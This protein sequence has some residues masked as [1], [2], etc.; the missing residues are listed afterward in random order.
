M[1]Y[2]CC[3]ALIAVIFTAS[4]QAGGLIDK[5]DRFTGNRNVRWNSVPFKPE[6]FG[7]SSYAFYLKDTA[8][9]AAYGLSLLTW[10]DQW[11]FLDCHRINWLV[12]GAPAPELKSKYIHE[13]AGSA[14]SERFE[15]RVDRDALK[16]MASA[17]LVEFSIC[18]QE[19]KVSNEDLGGIR[20]V[21][22]VAK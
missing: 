5:T 18:G 17:K 10:A 22:E 19:Y 20:Q 2:R 1:N 16:K 12:D 8:E 7:V 11:Q 21:L 15:F 9:P 6:T 13:M 4:V 14:T 3:V